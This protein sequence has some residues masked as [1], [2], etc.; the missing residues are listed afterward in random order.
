MH[1][2]PGLAWKSLQVRPSTAARGDTVEGMKNNI[3]NDNSNNSNNN[4]IH[5]APCTMQQYPEGV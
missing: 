1:G 3:K 4:A 2:E 5:N